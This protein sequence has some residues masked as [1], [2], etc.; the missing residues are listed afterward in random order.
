LAVP[1][2]GATIALSFGD[3]ACLQNIGGDETTSTAIDTTETPDISST[4]TTTSTALTSDVTSSTM[5]TTTTDTESIVVDA[6]ST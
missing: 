6:T 2:I 4:S 5:S 1:V 3:P